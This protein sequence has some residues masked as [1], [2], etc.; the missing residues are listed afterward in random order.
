[1]LGPKGRGV[2]TFGFLEARRAKQNLSVDTPTRY[3]SDMS[4]I[5]STTAFERGIQPLI[6]VMVGDNAE[7]LLGFRPDPA[8]QRRV[9][10][11]A[12]KCNEGELTEAER[13]EYEGYV[14]AND[15]IAILMRQ[16]RR[17]LHD[18]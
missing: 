7:K 6:E 8:L 9:E 15:F 11:L 18:Q 4:T 14:R 5:T 1:M 3:S 10:E 17:R 16:A 13:D 2:G 12:A